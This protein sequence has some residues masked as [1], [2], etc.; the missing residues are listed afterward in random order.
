MTLRRF[1]L[2]A[3]LFCIPALIMTACD[4]GDKGNQAET[5]PAV[6]A[7]AHAGHDHPAGEHP[8]TP[9]SNAF[10]SG[11]IVET[12]NSG[13]YSY[14][15]VDT[16]S[17]R[18]WMAGPETAGLEVG[19]KVSAPDGMEMKN[20]QAKSLDKTFESIFFVGAIQTGDGQAAASGSHGGMP[21]GMGSTPGGSTQLDKAEVE[22]VAKLAGGYTVE[23]IYGQSAALGGQ[24]VKLRGQV[25]KFTPNI[26]G[27]NWVHIQDGTGSADTADL[28][29]TT[30]ASVAPGDLVVVEGPLSVD[31]DFGAGYKYH[32]IIEGATV[33]KQ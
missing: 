12:M 4:G 28:T 22:G 7:D 15:L 30:S 24:T 25:V 6:E 9:A 31:K 11:N 33:T 18:V 5:T 19:Q 21:M 8:E 17:N 10:L 23:E 14:V 13:G 3:A 26:M 27:T 29:V 20:F 16:G 2:L 1:Y 32:V